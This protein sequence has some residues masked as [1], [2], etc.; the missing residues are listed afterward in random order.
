M[1]LLWLDR[2]CGCGRKGEELTGGGRASAAGERE[3]RR[4]LPQRWAGAELG[5]RGAGPE[6][7]RR[8]EAGDRCWAGPA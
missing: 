2:G 1:L 4:Q 7:R 8:G 5:W 6:M 3:A